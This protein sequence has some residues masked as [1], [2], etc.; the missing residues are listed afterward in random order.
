MATGTALYGVGLIVGSRSEANDVLG[1]LLTLPFSPIRFLVLV[2][3]VYLCL[4]SVPRVE[5]SSLVP[6]TWKTAAKL[7]TLVA[8]P[9]LLMGIAFHHWL[10]EPRGSRPSLWET[11][12]E[13]VGHGFS[14]LRDRLRPAPHQD[15]SIQLLDSLGRTIDQITGHGDG[16]PQDNRILNLTE[17]IIANALQQRAS[18]I[19]IDPKD[20][21][22]YTLRLR[23]DGI[24]KPVQDLNA[25]T[26]KAVIN[27]IKAVSNMD[28]AEKRRPQDGAFVAQ[29]GDLTASFRVASAGVVNGEKLA[30]R[31]LSQQAGAYKL[32]QTGLT[33]KQLAAIREMMDKPSGMIL[34]CGPT[35]S[36]KTTTLYGMLNELDRLTRNVI[37]VED[38]IEA[39]LPHTSQIEINAKADITFAKALRSILR[40]DPDVI[41]VGEIRDEETAEIA[42]RASQTGH[43]VL[44][45]IHCDSNAAAVVRLLDL[46]VSPLLISSGLSALLS[47][48]LLRCLCENCK[49]P[50]NFS[51]I[52][53]RELA[54]NQID[55]GS[56]FEPAGC[57]NC[58]GTGYFGRTAIGDLILVDEQFRAR[59][60][61]N[62]SVLAEELRAHGTQKGRSTLHKQGLRKVVEGLTSLQ[63][64]KRVV[65]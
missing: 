17:Q 21:A 9:F 2:V 35:G 40:Q 18:D 1:D 59:I 53:T 65:G 7:A 55:C 61:Q 23:I 13:G 12:R 43:L 34:V 49:R 54:K 24:L 56:V 3:W 50:A 51:Q 39:V 38:P 62:T 57:E 8:G 60:A 14:G 52:K 6:K 42:L 10:K 28:I 11:A 58:H 33:A 30:I 32:D 64:L 27:S 48:R 37:T 63:E 5:S 46:G 31:V 4:Y 19:L 47:Q 22:T 20:S 45:T 25:V 29:K 16:Q 44:A 15:R 41:C 36:G 26:C